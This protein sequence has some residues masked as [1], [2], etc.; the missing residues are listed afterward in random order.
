VS[1]LDALRS[2]PITPQAKLNTFLTEFR[3]DRPLLSAF[4]EGREDPSF[5]RP[6]IERF[7]QRIEHRVKIYQLGRK[8][9]V[10]DARRFISARY[11]AHPRILYFV[12]KDHDDLVHDAPASATE[13]TLFVTSGYSIESYCACR[14]AVRIVLLDLWG[15][16]S[17]NPAIQAAEDQFKAA[18][19]DFYNTSRPWMAWL[20]AARRIGGKPN[21]TNVALRKVVALDSNLQATF[22]WPEEMPEYLARMCGVKSPPTDSAIQAVS[23]ELRGLPPKSWLRGKVELAFF[24]L[25]LEGLE[26]QAKGL[27]KKNTVRTKIGLKNAVEIVA[28]RLPCP[29]DLQT[30]LDTIID[31]AESGTVSR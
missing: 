29:N 11:G 23:E 3:P 16:D 10:L 14:E 20:V 31:L 13:L 17:S 18:L 22:Q 26:K 9:E 7:A 19:P 25:F 4:M 12:D 28:P 15:F 1:F 30:F 27:D 6:H 2:A 24:V 8:R 21:S 5:Y